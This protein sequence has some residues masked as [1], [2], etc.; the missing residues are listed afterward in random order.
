MGRL[1]LNAVRAGTSSQWATAG[2][3]ASLG[4]PLLLI[5]EM[6]YDADA[7]RW[8]VGDGVEIDWDGL[9]WADPFPNADDVEVGDILF[10]DAGKFHVVDTGNFK[11]EP[12]DTL[13]ATDA[14]VLRIGGGLAPDAFLGGLGLYDSAN[15]EFRY[16]FAVDGGFK[17]EGS[18]EIQDGLLGTEA[19][20]G[21]GAL[22]GILKLHDG[23]NNSNITFTAGDFQL[24]IADSAGPGVIVNIDGEISTVGDATFGGAISGQNLQLTKTT[25]QLRLRYDASNYIKVTVGSNGTAVFDSVGSSPGFSFL[26]PVAI[27][28]PLTISDSSSR[29]VTLA[30]SFG[31]GTAGTWT[32][33]LAGGTFASKTGNLGQFAA[34]TSAQLAGVISDETGSGS[35][36]FGTAP[37][38]GSPVISGGSINNAVIGGTTPAAG[39]FTAG[40]FTGNLIVDGDLTINGS[41]FD[42]FTANMAVEDGLV[43]YGVGNAADTLDLGFYALYTS[44]GAKYTGL[45]RDATDAKWKL[46]TGLQSEPTTTVNVAGTGYELAPMQLGGLEVFHATA[47][48]IQIGDKAVATG[49]L[50]L[51]EAGDAVDFLFTPA[52]AAMNL[53]ASVGTVDFSA[54]GQITGK[55]GLVAG[56]GGTTTGTLILY[57]S[58]SGSATIATNATGSG[59]TFSDNATPATSGGAALGTS[60]LPWSGLVLSGGIGAAN[61]FGINIGSGN[62]VATH[63]SS[64]AVLEVGI[65]D[66]RITTAGTNSASVVTVGGAQTLTGKTLTAPKFASGGFIADAN[67]NELLIFTTTPSAVNEVTF[68]NAATGN[69]PTF[70]ASGGDTNININFNSKGSGYANFNNAIFSGA[71]ISAGGALLAAAAS[72]I[73]INLAANTI[74]TGWLLTNPVAATSGNQRYSPAIRWNGQGWKTNATAASQAVDFRSYVVPVQ[75]TANPTGLWKL[76]AAINGG[77]FADCLTV[78]SAGNVAV[79][80]TLTGTVLS[81]ASLNTSATPVASPG[82]GAAWLSNAV[83]NVQASQRASERST[84]LSPSPSWEATAVFEPNVFFANGTYNMIYT[85]GWNDPAIGWA[86]ASSPAGPWT[87]QN[88]NTQ[89]LGRGQGGEAGDIC[90]PSVI[91]IGS[92]VYIFYVDAIGANADLKLASAP[93]SNIASITLVGT[94]LTHDATYTG[95]A[96]IAVVADTIAGG[97]TMWFEYRSTA[98]GNIWKIGRATASAVTG[99]W[100]ITHTSLTTLQRG[101]GSWGGP[102]V[103][104]ENGQ[105]VMIYHAAHTTNDSLPSEIYRAVSADGITWVQDAPT[106]LRMAAGSEWDQVADPF[107]YSDSHGSHLYYAG[108]NNPA[109]A[110][111]I[112]YTFLSRGYSVY[113]GTKWVPTLSQGLLSGRKLLAQRVVTTA[114]ASFQFDNVDQ[115][116]TNLV[117]EIHGRSNKAAVAAESV[118]MQF[119]GDTGNNYYNENLSGAAAA[120][121]AS[122]ALAVAYV[123]LSAIPAATATANRSGQSFAV[124][125]NYART[126][127]NKTCRTAGIYSTG[128]ASASIVVD[129]DASIWANTAAITAIKVFLSAGGSFMAGTV[130]SVYGEP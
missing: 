52:S 91:V 2:A 29:A 45:F 89:I 83:A 53:T 112:N 104:I 103:K 65:G 56:D 127:F 77:S 123:R 43:K 98:T 5:R 35:L 90:R 30:M 126:T 115:T 62:W 49:V 54:T 51:A 40:Q 36:V 78:D 117:I 16:F 39:T 88:S 27:A 13:N 87:R 25:E 58:S 99:T 7:R 10:Y 38:I 93:T 18:L 3:A 101:S 28:A 15:E 9:P 55:N 26:D 48:V 102:D 111:T 47:P 128:T 76:E 34:T 95:F 129:N 37:T 42:A 67:G 14:K 79:A 113:D 118:W 46:F 108:M 105:Y 64:P 110:G 72:T 106:F 22:S 125:S 130:I 21:A 60:A 20:F 85:G 63:S 116:Y 92:T 97:Y 61:G 107:V 82:V 71:D 24:D 114:I 19:Q 6:G 73:N 4:D 75:G 69:S 100:T 109:S 84:I 124:I 1:Q 32:Y 31:G 17:V 119:N 11:Y 57:G 66:L 80:G 44:S 23:P 122:E 94:M 12:A 74:G 33:D 8:K 86:T 96:N 59:V 41:A 70:T 68:A 121:S 120:S 50:K 81:N